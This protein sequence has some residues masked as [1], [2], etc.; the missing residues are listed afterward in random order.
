[1]VPR[2]GVI[3]PRLGKLVSAADEVSVREII[4]GPITMI[5]GLRTIMPGLT[6]FM[7]GLM[8]FM[9]GLTK[10]MPGI[11]EVLHGVIITAP[12]AWVNPATVVATMA[13]ITAAT[14]VL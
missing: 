12:C 7:P 10:F 14:I 4:R 3:V 5:L 6:K 9:P 1:M 8:T 13:A 11:G 2:R